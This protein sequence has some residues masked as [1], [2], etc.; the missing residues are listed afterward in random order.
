MIGRTL[1]I[2]GPKE[3]AA[4][5]DALAELADRFAAAEQPPPAVR[6]SGGNRKENGWFSS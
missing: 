4:I 5:V 1:G 3:L 6:R 2:A